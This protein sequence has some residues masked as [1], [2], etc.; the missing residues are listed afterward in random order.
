MVAADKILA[1]MRRNPRDW[2]MEDLETAAGRLGMSIRKAPGSH[3]TFSAPGCVMVVTVPARKPVK[4]AYV[5]MFV[6]LADEMLES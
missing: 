2:R 3:V 1:R 6:K 4:P 5:R